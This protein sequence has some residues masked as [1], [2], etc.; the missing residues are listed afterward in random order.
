MPYLTPQALPESDDCR[1][2]SIP[3]DTE[4]LALF[5]G[6]LT[7]LTKV[8]N[9]E[10]SGGLSVDETVA[11]MNEIID[12]WWLSVCAAC[13]TPGGYRVIRIGS[14][15][16]IEQLDESGNWVAGTDEYFIPPPEAREGGTPDSQICLAAKN[17]VNVLHTLYESLADSYGESLDDAEALA[18][19]IA[20]EVA[21]VGFAFAPIV[22]GIYAFFAP[23]FALL[24]AALE[25]LTAD[26]WDESV[27][28]QITC[29]LV[30]C[31][32]NAAG[33][34]TFD[35][36]CFV[37]KLN[38]L[39]TGFGLT[40]EQL[41]LYGQIAYLL[42]FI[43]GIDGLNLA[44]R[45]TAISDDDCSNCSDEWCFSW[46]FET[47]DG[48]WEGLSGTHWVDG[49]GWTG[50]DLDPGSQ[51]WA[52]IRKEFD[53]SNITQIGMFY[54]KPSGSGGNDVIAYVLYDA[55]TPVSSEFPPHEVGCP[56]D[57][58]W[59]VDVDADAAELYLNASLDVVTV[60]I[61]SAVIRGTG[62]CPFGA[63]NC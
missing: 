18:A 5:G 11:K 43:G 35:Y 48:G 40:A 52:G 9:W 62:E 26:L 34:V 20:V 22:F 44:A 46:D 59:D 38:S 1:S 16:R 23:L 39:D 14:T 58:F 8:W 12:T 47:T 55:A 56:T 33:V 24:F 45:T 54:C 61:I 53:L 13:T 10:Y 4:W 15:G 63:P 27:S 57:F 30:E 41:R 19:L 60:Y 17:A 37:N 51:S 28:D 2:L 42:Y 3:A 49:Q 25:Y 7:E 36:D 32:D 29:F 31:A 6:A 21:L 50:I